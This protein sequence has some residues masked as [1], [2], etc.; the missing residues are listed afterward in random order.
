MIL[1]DREARVFGNGGGDR[2][3][4]AAV[5]SEQADADRLVGS[6]HDA[7]H[8]R[9]RPSAAQRRRALRGLLPVNQFLQK[10]G[11]AELAVRAP[12]LRSCASC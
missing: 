8:W 9:K 4:H 5:R 2:L 7:C 6:A 12:A 3:A 1:V 11:P 10:H